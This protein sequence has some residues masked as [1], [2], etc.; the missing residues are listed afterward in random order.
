MR[1]LAAAADVHPGA[2][3]ADAS[4]TRDAVRGM[5]FAVADDPLAIQSTNCWQRLESPI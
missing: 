4:P 2:V 1:A 5:D 3:N